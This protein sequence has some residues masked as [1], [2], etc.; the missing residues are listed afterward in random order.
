MN[1]P[2]GLAKR[3]KASMNMAI[4]TTYFRSV[5]FFGGLNKIFMVVNEIFIKKTLVILAVYNTVQTM[6][7][8]V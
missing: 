1:P 5:V 8:H 3:S 7:R 2:E 6:S 4:N